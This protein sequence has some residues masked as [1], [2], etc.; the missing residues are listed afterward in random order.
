MGGHLAILEAMA[1]SALT[2][3]PLRTGWR[4]Q[5]L[6]LPSFHPAVCISLVARQTGAARAE[7]RVLGAQPPH[8]PLVDVAAPFF[9]DSTD[10]PV[11]VQAAVRE[12]AVSP[13]VSGSPLILDGMSYELS[14]KDGMGLVARSGNVSSNLDVANMLHELLPELLARLREE[15]CVAALQRAL[16]YTE[17]LPRVVGRQPRPTDP[18]P[19]GWSPKRPKTFVIL[20][21]AHR[22]PSCSV[23][24]TRFR[25][26]SD[27]LI[28]PAC[29]RSFIV[30]AD[31]LRGAREE[32]AA[33]GNAPG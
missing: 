4:A 26:L 2:P 31:V 12:C 9:L 33:A 1:L 16:R 5:I 19:R 14:Y 8:P 25:K 10:V 6:L 23:S 3:E 30:V 22:C 17:L 18:T 29:A 21:E 15:S 32:D 28:C 20:V 7:I 27:R 13:L 24:H 11:R